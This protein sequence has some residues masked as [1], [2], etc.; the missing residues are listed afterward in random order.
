M[1]LHDSRN[2]EPCR[3]ME[4]FLQHEADGTAS[5]LAKWYAVAHAARCAPC[6]SFLKTLR[7]NIG[8]LRAAR[9]RDT[10]QD[11]IARLEHGEW[12]RP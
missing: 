4:N 1:K 5:G 10:D 7:M 3:H 2:T 12:R 6:G 9:S 11:A 8:L